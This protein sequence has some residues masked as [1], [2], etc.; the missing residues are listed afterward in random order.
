MGR[1]ALF[2][3]KK[4]NRFY[5][6]YVSTNTRGIDVLKKVKIVKVMIF[7]VWSLVNSME[8]VFE[9]FQHLIFILFELNDEHH[10]EIEY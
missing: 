4:K 1:G 6:K 10:L 7:E 3:K 8:N 9:V 5:G 2:A